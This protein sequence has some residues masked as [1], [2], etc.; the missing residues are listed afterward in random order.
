MAPEIDILSGNSPLLADSELVATC[1]S[2]K[3]R[4]VGKFDYF[5]ECYL[6]CFITFIFCRTN[7]M[8]FRK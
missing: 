2:S 8:V 6:I 3:G 1:E 4:P 5:N 7:N